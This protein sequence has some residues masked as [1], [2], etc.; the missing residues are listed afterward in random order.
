M[1]AGCGLSSRIGLSRPSGLRATRCGGAIQ[2]GLPL[3][4][5]LRHRKVHFIRQGPHSRRAVWLLFLGGRG[6][7]IIIPPRACRLVVSTKSRETIRTPADLPQLDIA[8]QRR[9]G[10]A[11]SASVFLRQRA[12]VHAVAVQAGV[13][14]CCRSAM[15]R[16]TLMTYVATPQIQRIPLALLQTAVHPY[17]STGRH[18]EIGTRV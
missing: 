14:L 4:T 12:A 10:G 13:H 3:A 8:L 1:E 6:P 5:G 15:V 2:A 11:A 16:G 17:E 9:T 7:K 18:R